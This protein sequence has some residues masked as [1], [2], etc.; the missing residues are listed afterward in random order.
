MRLDQKQADFTRDGII[1]Y[2]DFAILAGCWQ[3][4]QSD[5][6]WYVLC[7]LLEDGRIDVADLSILA[8]DWFWIRK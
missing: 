4:R 1:N 8:D 5:N 7:D 2:E 3:N 6:R